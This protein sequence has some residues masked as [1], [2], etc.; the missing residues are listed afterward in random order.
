MAAGTEAA[1]ASLDVVEVNPL[2]DL[3]G[4]SARWAA[5]VVWHFLSGLARRQEPR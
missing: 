1:V 2:F 4:R 3:D 5:L